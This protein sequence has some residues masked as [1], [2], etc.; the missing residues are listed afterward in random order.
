MTSRELVLKDFAVEPDAARLRKAAHLMVSSL[1]GSLALVTCREPLKASVT[2]QLRTLLQQAGVSPPADPGSLDQALQQAV[3]D[4][5]ELGCSLIEQAA[6]ERAIRDIDEA[7]APAVL[8]RQKHREKHGPAGQPFFDPA[9]LQG[10]FPGALPE[11]LRPR[12]GHLAPAPQ[13]IY[14]DFA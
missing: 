10:R 11:S 7:L 4:N 5:L 2:S 9:Y 1:A 12:P 14:E 3:V 8:A 6:T 13:R